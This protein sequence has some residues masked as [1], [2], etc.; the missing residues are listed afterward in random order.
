MVSSMIEPDEKLV[1]DELLKKP[2]PEGERVPFPRQLES[3]VA[4][5]INYW[6]I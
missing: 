4:L 6:K 3:T 2:V 1:S 5:S